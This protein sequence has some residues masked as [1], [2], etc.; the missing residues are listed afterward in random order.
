MLHRKIKKI[1]SKKIVASSEMAK[2]KQ[3]MFSWSCFPELN[4]KPNQMA[5]SFV[6]ISQSQQG[7]LRAGCKTSAGVWRSVWWINAQPWYSMSTQHSHGLGREQGQWCSQTVQHHKDSKQRFKEL[8]ERRAEGTVMKL[9]TEKLMGSRLF[10]STVW[11]MFTEASSALFHNSVY[12]SSVCS[13]SWPELVFDTDCKIQ[14]L[15]GPNGK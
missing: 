13:K 10:R 7:V 3:L 11:C 14:S 4:H 8:L 1:Q 15:K 2:R 6:S 5:L 9:E 12:S